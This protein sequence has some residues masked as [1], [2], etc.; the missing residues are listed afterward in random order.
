MK[1]P[2]PMIPS[3]TS[4]VASNKPR[5]RASS[6]FDPGLFFEELIVENERK[7]YHRETLDTAHDLRFTIHDSR[8]TIY[9]SRPTRYKGRQCPTDPAHPSPSGPVSFRSRT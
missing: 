6:G 9:D 1:I 7:P 5:R 2:E 3:I 8:F 4:M